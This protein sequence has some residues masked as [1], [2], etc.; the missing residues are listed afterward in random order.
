MICMHVCM[1][2]YVYIFYVISCIG[3]A[4]AGAVLSLDARARRPPVGRPTGCQPEERCASFERS[5]H[6]SGNPLIA[7]IKYHLGWS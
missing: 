7:S 3:T 4:E 5:N 2:M 1:Y 6:E